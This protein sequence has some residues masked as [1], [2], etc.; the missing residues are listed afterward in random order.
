MSWK[1]IGIWAILA[2]FVAFTAWVVFE[3]GYLGF[4]E[5]L[6]GTAI[7]VQVFIDLAIALALFTVWMVRDARA[8]GV[9]PVPYFVL[10]LFLGSIGPLLYLALRP[11]A[12][13]L[14]AMPRA[15]HA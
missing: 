13:P 3:H 15:L 7:G 9:S 4:F 1:K 10:T 8:R 14:A 12:E 6:L 5:F 11:E 2:D